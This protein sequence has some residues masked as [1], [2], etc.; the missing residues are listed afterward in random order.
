MKIENKVTKQYKLFGELSVGDVFIYEGEVF[1]KTDGETGDTNVLHFISGGLDGLFN[2]D[3]V[4]VV[5]ATLTV[6]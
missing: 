6:E 1:I 3:E 2:D 5:N 4:R